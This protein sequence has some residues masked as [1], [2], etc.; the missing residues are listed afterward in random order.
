MIRPMDP[1]CSTGSAVGP[2]HS[3]A[4]RA[5]ELGGNG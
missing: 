5:Q 1:W 3:A 4:T 2:A